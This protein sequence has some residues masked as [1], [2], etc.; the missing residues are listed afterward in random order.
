LFKDNYESDFSPISRNLAFS[1]A[2][3]YLLY[4]KNQAETNQ[5]IGKEELSDDQLKNLREIDSSIY[6]GKAM[7]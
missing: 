4:V 3:N 1:H 7:A 6:L 5:N 2:F